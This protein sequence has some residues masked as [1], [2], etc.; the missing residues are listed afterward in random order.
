MA[1]P[2]L[3]TS[4]EVPPNL[5]IFTSIRSDALLLTHPL[6][7]FSPTPTSSPSPSQFYLLPYHR[8]RLLSAAQHFAF[9]HCITLLSGPS[10]LSIL[11]SSLETH[12]LNTYSSSTY[13]SPVRIRIS[14]SPNGDLTLASAPTPAL[15]LGAFFPLSLS[16]SPDT[17]TAT[18]HI[19]LSPI[20][21]EPCPYTYHKTTN[22]DMYDA[23]RAHLSP[24]ATDVEVLIVNGRGEVMEGSLTTPYFWR[25]GQWVT[26]QESCGG[27]R[28][29]TRR[30]ALERGVAV[31]GV[32]R[33]LDVRMGEVVWLSNGVRG[34]GWGRVEEVVSKK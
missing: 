4:L 27:N 31:E 34:F 9:Q 1:H 10:G 32:V 19:Q 13:P 8:D 17:A 20:A 25:E 21:I 3:S 15:P 23:A 11:Q 14:I 22:R 5:G 12:L 33:A 29:T 2:L 24:A 16:P 18:W 26:P 28:G 30:W 6:N 7:Q